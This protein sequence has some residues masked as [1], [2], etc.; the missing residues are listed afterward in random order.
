MDSFAKDIL[1][2]KSGLG[3]RERN[4]NKSKTCL[5]DGKMCGKC[6][7]GGRGIYGGSGN[8]EKKVSQFYLGWRWGLGWGDFTE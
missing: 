4:V 6:I 8:Q 5:Q 2:I 3:T 1:C 7:Y